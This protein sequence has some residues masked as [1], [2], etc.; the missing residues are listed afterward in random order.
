[1]WLVIP[2]KELFLHAGALRTWGCASGS[3][4]ACT[5]AGLTGGGGGM[6]QRILSYHMTPVTQAIA[7]GSNQC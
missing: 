2:T 4:S 7:E 6:K 3:G 5:L 1:M